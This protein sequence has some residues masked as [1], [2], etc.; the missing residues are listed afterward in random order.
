[1][2]KPENITIHQLGRLSVDENDKLYWGGRPVKT[3]EKITLVW[4]VNWS[5]IIGAF[6]TMVMAAIGIWKFCCS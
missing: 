6:S 2:A 3:E 4:W 1:M 5:I